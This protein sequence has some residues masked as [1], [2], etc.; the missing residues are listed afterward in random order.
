MRIIVLLLADAAL[1]FGLVKRLPRNS[2]FGWSD[3]HD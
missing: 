3:G 2:S 1:L